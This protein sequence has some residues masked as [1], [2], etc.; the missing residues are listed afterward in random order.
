MK[1]I[2]QEFYKIFIKKKFLIIFIMLLVFQSSTFKVPS[3]FE[4]VSAET[5]Y[6]ERI[7]A[8]QGPFDKDILEDIV[9]NLDRD[10]SL[11]NSFFSSNQGRLEDK[12]DPSLL[13][14]LPGMTLLR[15]QI[16]YVR[17]DH[18]NRYFMDVNAWYNIL[19]DSPIDFIFYF[20]II[21]LTATVLG[22]EYDTGMDVL[23]DTTRFGRKKRKRWQFSLIIL[24]L[25]LYLIFIHLYQLLYVFPQVN[26]SMSFPVQS[27]PLYANSIFNISLLETYFLLIVLRIIGLIFLVSITG[28]LVKLT[29]SALTSSFLSGLLVLVPNLI[30]SPKIIYGLPLPNRLLMASGL[31]QGIPFYTSSQYLPN[32]P[33]NEFYLILI[34]SIILILLLNYVERNGFKLKKPFLFLSLIMLTSCASPNHTDTILN[35]PIN[36]SI[37]ES[38]G[39]II[40]EYQTWYSVDPESRF[41]ERLDSN[42]TLDLTND[43]QSNRPLWSAYPS[44]KGAYLLAKENR[45]ETGD[46]WYLKEVDLDTMQSKKV[47]DTGK[48]T[49]I[50]SNINGSMPMLNIFSEVYQTLDTD[51]LQGFVI[52]NDYLYHI[53]GNKIKR[54]NFNGRDLETLPIN[55][56]SMSSP[57]SFRGDELYYLDPSYTIRKLNLESFEDSLILEE[58]SQFNI[59]SKGINYID[60]KN[61]GTYRF[62]FDNKTSVLF[63]DRPVLELRDYNNDTYFL[64]NLQLYRKNGENGEEKFVSKDVIRYYILDNVLFTVDLYGETEFIDLQ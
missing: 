31:I 27:L 56:S 45:L 61:E 1:V 21:V 19:D 64:D 57:F 46:T 37:F 49:L 18:N 5:Y 28:F 55:L 51:A 36:T 20:F 58:V 16:D 25:S 38:N 17:M 8:L 59:D 26:N 42:I 52:Y 13:G 29:R 4:S 10:I 30:F 44:D 48:N 14:S 54:S 53:Y 6:K 23:N 11:V 62:S 34:S 40:Y 33:L 35:Y 32:I 39:N 15:S 12:I 47:I 9:K 63:L 43:G 50:P 7:S 60:S 41:I 24:S 22:F 3:F 2:G